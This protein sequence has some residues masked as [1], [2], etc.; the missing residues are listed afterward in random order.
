MNLLPAAGVAWLAAQLTQE[1]E[2]KQPS[3]ADQ[4]PGYGGGYGPTPGPSHTGNDKTT[5]PIVETGPKDGLLVNVPQGIDTS[6]PGYESKKPIGT[7][8]GT[9]ILNPKPQLDLIMLAVPAGDKEKLNNGLKNIMGEMPVLETGNKSSNDI[10]R[11][12]QGTF[13]DATKVFNQLGLINIRDFMTSAGPGKKGSLSDGTRVI[14]RPGSSDGAPTI[15]IID[16]NRP[17]P[18][19]VQEIRFGQGKK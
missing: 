8:G 7:D 4:I 6:V 2:A 10:S 12:E 16:I 18:R 14:I 13:E 1:F 17:K 5:N 15:Q 3:L 11:Y 19:T 9:V